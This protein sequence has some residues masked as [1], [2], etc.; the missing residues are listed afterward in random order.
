MIEDSATDYRYLL[1]DRDAKFT[2]AFDRVFAAQ[3]IKVIHTPIRAPNA[4]AYAECWVR[5]VRQECL[6]HLIIVNEQHLKSVLR[7]YVRY[8][9][10]RRPHQGLEQRFQRVHSNRSIKGRFIV[11]RCSAD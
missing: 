7:E 6:D 11:A 1:H 3:N 10:I 2:S 8:Y 9:N 5:S 4:N